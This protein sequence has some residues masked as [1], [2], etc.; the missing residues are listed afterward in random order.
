MS[1]PFNTDVITSADQLYGRQELLDSLRMAA[2]MNINI[3]LIGTRRFGKT[4]LFRTMYRELSSDDSTCYPVYLDFKSVSGAIS[5]TSAVYKYIISVVISSMCQ[6]GI[7]DSDELTFA[8]TVVIKPNKAWNNV[9]GQL[10]ALQSSDSLGLFQEAIPWLADLLGKPILMLIDEYEYMIKFSF[11]SPD[12]FFAIRNLST[13][14]LPCSDQ[15]ILVFWV[16][17]AETWKHLGE[18]TGSGWGNTMNSPTYVEPLE[19]EE[20]LRMW[21]DEV[22]KVNSEESRNFLIGKAEFAW[23]KSGGVPLY[24][25]LIGRE[26]LLKKNADVDFKLLQNLFDEILEGNIGQEEKTILKSL[27]TLARRMTDSKALTDLM[28]KGLVVYDEETKRHR[29]GIGFLADYM[30]KLDVVAVT[31]M[32]QTYRIVDEICKLIEHINNH[33]PHDMIFKPVN[34][35]VSLAIDMKKVTT[36][37]ESMLT[38]ASAAYKT[39]L[40]RSAQKVRLDNGEEK[41]IFGRKLPI[42]FRK[43]V[44]SANPENGQFARALDRLR[45]T[46]I[47]LYNTARPVNNQMDVDEMLEY[48]IGKKIQPFKP[49]EFKE[50]QLGV[51]NK[52]KQELE[53]ML[54]YVCGSK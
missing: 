42:G 13:E 22:A 39:Y 25:K 8:G 19:K 9:Y 45:Q 4:C 35:E 51:L 17:G 52:F 26:Y 47:H 29:I 41:N 1:I 33:C 18:V 7:L 36:D 43:T 46:Y 48:F 5:G 10:N 14:T 53:K 11:S 28:N 24:G 6:S 44:D 37:T 38:F 2:A 27:S 40:E 15:R 49:N 20:F 23:E 30:K 32:P 21:T 16:A 31:R 12:D 34:E 54:D 3:Q 50:L